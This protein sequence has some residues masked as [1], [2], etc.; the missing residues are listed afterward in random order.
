M[1]QKGSEKRIKTCDVW[2]PTPSKECKLWTVAHAI[3]TKSE[4][5]K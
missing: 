2:V 4:F 1:E 5:K 3:I